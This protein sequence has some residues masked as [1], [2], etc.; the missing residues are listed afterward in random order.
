MRNKFPS[1]CRPITFWVEMDLAVFHLAKFFDRIEIF[2]CLTSTQMELIWNL[3]NLNN[4]NFG[5]IEKFRLVENRL[6][7]PFPLRKIFRRKK[8]LWNVIGRHKFWSWKFSTFNNV[9]FGKFSV[10]GNFSWVEMGL[11]WIWIW[12]KFESAWKSA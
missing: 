11:Y 7:G 4:R 5:S 10:R 1:C 3:L 12:T 6:K 2:F 9:I 8:I